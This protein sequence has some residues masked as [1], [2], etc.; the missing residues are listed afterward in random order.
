[1][2]ASNIQIYASTSIEEGQRVLLFGRHHI[3]DGCRV[4]RYRKD[5]TPF[6][7]YRDNPQNGQLTREMA[8]HE[9]WVKWRL[10]HGLPA[11]G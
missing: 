5:G 9:T 2:L 6:W 8:G 4:I 11:E 1:M 3:G 7:G 10:R